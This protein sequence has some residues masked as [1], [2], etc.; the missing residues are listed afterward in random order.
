MTVS[1]YYDTVFN[2]RQVKDDQSN[3]EQNA[4]PWFGPASAC[5][6]P[7]LSPTLL[8]KNYVCIQLNTNPDNVYVL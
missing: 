5:P 2:S 3:P 4:V 6:Q 8:P 1:K 7:T